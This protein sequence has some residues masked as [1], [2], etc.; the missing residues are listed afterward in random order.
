MILAGK[1]VEIWYPD[2]IASQNLVLSLL[3]SAVM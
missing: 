3:F 2:F 1:I